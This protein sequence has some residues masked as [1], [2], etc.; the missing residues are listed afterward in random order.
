MKKVYFVAILLA[1]VLSLS[2][3]SCDRVERQGTDT[4]TTTSTASETTPLVPREELAYDGILYYEYAE[5]AGYYS[6]MY[7]TYD[8]ATIWNSATPPDVNAPTASAGFELAYTEAIDPALYINAVQVAVENEFEK[9]DAAAIYD[10]LEFSKKQGL[11][12]M[13]LDPETHI[14]VYGTQGLVLEVGCLDAYSNQDP[15]NAFGKLYYALADLR[16][17][18]DLTSVT[19]RAKEQAKLTAVMNITLSYGHDV[20]YRTADK[21]I[22]WSSAASLLDFDFDAPLQNEGR[23]NVKEIAANGLIDVPHIDR[24][25]LYTVNRAGYGM[26]DAAHQIVVLYYEDGTRTVVS[27][28]CPN[29]EWHPIWAQI[30]EQ[31]NKTGT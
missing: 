5:E 23:E 8:T 28:T 12:P 29:M 2:L 25:P 15:K 16:N 3:I 17:S 21:V 31:L 9:L 10:D 30:D 26:D 6:C 20:E 13:A 18:M 14:A 4:E 27:R 11:I 22:T 24:L 19:Q 7:V 1:A